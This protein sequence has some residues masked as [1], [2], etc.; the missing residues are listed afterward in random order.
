M[1]AFFL[2]STIT[3]FYFI[4]SVIWKSFNQTVRRKLLNY[5]WIICRKWRQKNSLMYPFCKHDVPVEIIHFM[6]INALSCSACLK[7]ILWTFERRARNDIFIHYGGGKTWNVISDSDSILSST[8]LMR[9]NTP[10]L[11]LNGFQIIAR[12]QSE[13]HGKYL[14]ICY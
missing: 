2:L 12:L 10:I 5:F 3:E 1:K 6:S 8:I 7:V 4:S 14:A 9:F 13:K 11:S